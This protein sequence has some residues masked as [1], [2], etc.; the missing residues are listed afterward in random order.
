MGERETAQNCDMGPR[1]SPSRS[2]TVPREA[3]EASARVR[4]LREQVA[5]LRLHVTELQRQSRR[6]SLE[7]A[8]ELQYQRARVN[9]MRA[10]SSVEA[11]LRHTRRG[12]M[13]PAAAEEN[14]QEAEEEDVDS[15][16]DAGAGAA[17]DAVARSQT[18][19][20]VATV[21]PSPPHGDSESLAETRQ[22]QQA[23]A[24]GQSP[25]SSPLDAAMSLVEWLIH[26]NNVAEIER[27]ASGN[28][29]GARFA[30]IV[31]IAWSRARQLREARLLSEAVRGS[32]SAELIWACDEADAVGVNPATVAAARRRA[33]QVVEEELLTLA[34]SSE[35]AD[36]IH[37]AIARAELAGVDASVVSA[38]RIRAQQL[39]ESVH[40]LRLLRA[41]EDG[42]D[43][44]GLRHPRDVQGLLDRARVRARE[45]QCHGDAEASAEACT[46]CLEGTTHGDAEDLCVLVCGHA[47][48][49]SCLRQW[50]GSHDTCP[51]CRVPA[52]GEAEDAR[53]TTDNG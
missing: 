24:H 53:E 12:T 2:A 40:F 16:V 49:S 6:L 15:R 46:I 47:F 43:V 31:G 13:G 27:I 36:E 50:L 21:A 45:R 25:E 7:S 22:S 48:H 14:E 38:A 4:E 39:I 28:G 33:R 37:G 9:A 42:D 35:D 19:T 10:V 3:Q 5:A 32:N 30:E 26:S 44:G 23:I 34:V 41:S 8:R 29:V 51:N 20:N 1:P 17:D 52:G 11:A 18:E